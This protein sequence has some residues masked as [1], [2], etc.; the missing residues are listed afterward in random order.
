MFL[1]Q[2]LTIWDLIYSYPL[3]YPGQLPEQS[4]MLVQNTNMRLRTR[5]LTSGK[6]SHRGR[7]Y[8]VDSAH[9]DK[10]F[11]ENTIRVNFLLA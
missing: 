1:L 6:T 8:H 5:M 2:H 7:A 9:A 4:W 3:T 10:P 11:P